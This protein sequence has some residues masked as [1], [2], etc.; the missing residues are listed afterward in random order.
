MC[1][2]ET[3][4]MSFSIVECLYKELCW[5]HIIGH[6]FVPQLATWKVVI[7][8]SVSLH[9]LLTYHFESQFAMQQMW[10]LIWGIKLCPI[11]LY[12]HNS[13]MRPCHTR[14]QSQGYVSNCK[15][16]NFICGFILGVRI[17]LCTGFSFQVWFIK[18]SFHHIY[19]Y[20]QL[21][22]LLNNYLL[23]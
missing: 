5:Y 2:N 7:D 17:N 19:I 9:S 21:Y 16:F 14:F 15:D 11:M 23:L 6:N 4:V 8:K 1:F 3:S 18:F 13:Y 12:Q 22:Q 10:Q 20:I